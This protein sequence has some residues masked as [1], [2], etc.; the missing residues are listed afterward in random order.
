M[1][2]QMKKL[3]VVISIM[4]LAHIFS[5]EGCSYWCSY[6]P[7]ADGF[8]CVA[9]IKCWSTLF[10]RWCLAAN[11]IGALFFYAINTTLTLCWCLCSLF[12][13]VCVCVC[14]EAPLTQPFC[15]LLTKYFSYC[16]PVFCTQCSLNRI[17][18]LAFCRRLTAALSTDPLNS[19]WG[20]Q[21]IIASYRRFSSSSNLLYT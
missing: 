4:P 15:F 20:L 9:L 14:E 8:H 17:C 18:T 1:R 2:I 16:S 6:Y 7:N 3:V 12:R 13:R 5:T 11:S 10:G 19:L 21:L